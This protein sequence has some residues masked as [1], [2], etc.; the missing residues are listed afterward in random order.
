Y[1]QLETHRE[2]NPDAFVLVMQEFRRVLKP[3]GELYLSVPYGAHRLFSMFQQFD[4]KMLRRAVEAF[5][6]AA[7]ITRYYRYTA[8]G[9]NV[10]EEKDCDDCKYVEW[11]AQAWARHEYPNPVPVE[12]DHAAAAR[13]VACVRLIKERIFY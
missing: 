12:K 13:A 8:N 6:K 2:N 7:E 1:T 3:G 5:G 4:R 11:I 9:W 10:A